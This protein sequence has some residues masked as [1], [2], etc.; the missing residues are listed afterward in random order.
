MIINVYVLFTW[1]KTGPW[2]FRVYRLFQ[3]TF[4]THPSN[5]YQKAKEGFL[6]I[7]GEPGI[8]ERVCSIGVCWNNLRQTE[9]K[10]SCLS[11]PRSPLK[12]DMPNK[13]PRAI[14]CIWGWLL[15]APIPRV[16]PPFSLWEKKTDGKKVKFWRSWWWNMPLGF[17]LVEDRYVVV[18]FPRHNGNLSVP[19]QCQPPQD[20]MG[21]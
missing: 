7:I 17:L 13:F 16:F 11:P 15:R 21:I 4:G 10:N 5:L 9:K 14:R 6:F 20:I 3:H 8:A 1:T 12:G 19:P 2:L 18:F